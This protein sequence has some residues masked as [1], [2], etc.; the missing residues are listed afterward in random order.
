MGGITAIEWINTG[1]NSN[2]KDF[3]LAVGTQNGKVVL[4]RLYL[5]EVYLEKQTYP[6][7]RFLQYETK[8]LITQS[9][10]HLVSLIYNI[11]E[12]TKNW[13]ASIKES[14]LQLWQLECPH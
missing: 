13:F 12:T 7:I 3:H 6:F 9:D 1:R 8:Y 2:G 11:E 14:K 5:D 10:Y 4:F